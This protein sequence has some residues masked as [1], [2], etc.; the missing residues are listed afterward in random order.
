MKYLIFSLALL[1]S[2]QAEAQ[3]PTLSDKSEISII[4]IGPGANLYDCF[5]H[6]AFRVVDPT[7]GINDAYN[8]G[9]YNFSEGNFVGKFTMGIAQYELAKRPFPNFY[10]SYVAENR[11]ITEQVLNL[12]LEE[13]QAIFDALETN[14]LPQNKSYRYDPFFDN[15]ATRMRDI[16]KDVLGSAIVYNNDHLTERNTLRTLVDENSFNHPWVDFGIDVA[17]GAILDKEATPEEYMYL[18][19]YVLAAYDNAIIR[20]GSAP[21]KAVKRKTKLFESD[22]YERK[23]SSVS[24]TLVLSI[25]ALILVFIT[26][27]EYQRNVRYRYFDFTLMLITGLL[28]AFLL[29]LWFGTGHATAV[30]NLNILW[31]FAPNAVVAFYILKRQPP[32]WVRVY[33]RFL[34]IL[35][36]AMTMIWFAKIQVFNTAMIPLVILFAIRYGFL[37]QRGLVFK[38]A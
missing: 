26:Y 3:F 15:C 30:K 16:V 22:Y 25:V 5:G 18:P 35:L 37:W 6:S 19:D 21:V 1:F 11:W 9:T 32:K 7:L 17:L 20:R 33:V 24:P 36:M 12:T 2:L 38:R 8:Y 31:A 13:K 10:N 23:V 14:A 34:F 27:R 28:G 29:F 4:T